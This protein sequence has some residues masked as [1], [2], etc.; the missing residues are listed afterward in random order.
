MKLLRPHNKGVPASRNTMKPS[1]RT[2]DLQFLP[3]P[4][5]LTRQA[6]VFAL[7][8]AGVIGIGDAIL[9]PI[10]ADVQALF[11]GLAIHASYPGGADAISVALREGL[12]RDGYRLTITTDGI[13]IEAGAVSGAYYAV[14]T[15]RQ[16]LDQAGEGALPCLEIE[17]WPDFADRG[18]YYD[19]TRGR[20]PKLEQLLQLADQLSRFK[21]NQL[22][23]Y[24]EHT[25][26]FRGHPEIG[27]DASPLT[28][29]DIL[30]L[31][32]HCRARH[33]ELVPSLASFGHLATVLKHSQYHHLAE[34]LGVGK[35]IDPDAP[36]DFALHAWT[37]SPANPDS[38][39]FLDSLFAEFLPLFTSQRFNA[40]CD[41]V[42]DLGWGQSYEL[43]KQRG[44]GRVYLDHITKVAELARKYGKR[45]M[46]WG[47]I[48]RHHPELVAEIPKDLTVLDWAYGHNHK[49]EAI[50]DFKEA[51]LEFYA[52]PGT[53]S[54]I[55]LFPR[56]PEACANIAGFAAAGKKYGARGLLNTDWGDGGHYNFMEYSWHG[57]LFGAEQ[58][59]NTGAD[60]ASFTRRFV[61]RFLG[62]DDAE[63]AVALDDLGAISFRAPAHGS[64]SVWQ[65]IFFALPDDP[66]FSQAQSTG[67]IMVRD[68]KIVTGPF[69]IDAEMARSVLPRLEQIRAVF[70]ARS[71]DGA[72]ESIVG[73]PLADRLLCARHAASGGPTPKRQG[74]E[75]SYCGGTGFD[76]VGVL[77]YWLFAADTMVLAARKLAAFGQG[78]RADQAEYATITR[79]LRELRR[80]FERL[81]RARN[82]PSEIGVTLAR[83]DRLIRGT[84]VRAALAEAG[85]NRIRLTVTNSGTRAAT[86]A[87]TLSATAADSAVRVEAAPPPLPGTGHAA[88]APRLQ[89]MVP[90][91][92]KTGVAAAE[93]G[94][95]RLR[96]GASRSAEFTLEVSGR[97]AMITVKAAGSG[98]G[99][100]GASLTLYGERDWAIP[101]LDACPSD[102]AALPALL[103]G[104]EPRVARLADGP[105]AEARVALAGD[106]LAVV[107]TVHDVAVRRGDPVWRGSCFELFGCAGPGKA[108]GQIFLAPPTAEAP[109]TAF[110]LVGAIVPAPEIAV[111]AVATGPEGYTL[112]ARVPL[113][114]LEIP[115]G[116]K[117][118]R[119]EGVATARTANRIEHR[120]A[121]LFYATDNACSDSAGYGVIHA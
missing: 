8:A 40:C 20:V 77:P 72:S 10:A 59:W 53:N 116:T 7:P 67:G 50:R 62:R 65:T 48:I 115:A 27:K 47:D 106:Q 111:V 99:I 84:S 94:F 24:I 25:F 1:S 52:C 26:A 23:L 81:W 3:Q 13:R 87:V 9:Y 18:V 19:V 118:F 51:G 38:Y 58:A 103:A 119:L 85:P 102:L 55:A 114:L 46:F 113:A 108:I 69:R 89:E 16:L 14:Q 28:A 22:Q 45:M 91:S 90:T 112:A 121:S 117:E 31:D 29:E 83:Y 107:V 70:A 36:R 104:A 17:D 11:P 75:V 101:T 120:R 41:E 68:G 43:C 42:Y 37:L 57:Y 110:K 88:R 21:I 15:L 82:R 96:P 66:V 74:S 5:S 76:P 30:K 61:S 44:K 4:R 6:G 34:D 54:W 105:V 39:A 2:I 93:L 73:R 49:F 95:N 98:D 32:A 78:G 86:G 92:A 109:A 80:R 79:A 60:Q 63:F 64:A 100:H 56:L 35:Y 97:P 71:G 33:I 12:H